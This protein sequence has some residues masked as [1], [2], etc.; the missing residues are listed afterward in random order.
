MR[1][2]E[3]K[4]KT[5]AVLV[6]V[7]ALE[8]LMLIFLLYIREYLLL[9]PMGI[10]FFLI[11]YYYVPHLI[12]WVIGIEYIKDSSNRLYK[13]VEEML[14]NYGFIR[15]RLGIANLGS[16]TSFS[17]KKSPHDITLVLSHKARGKDNEYLAG[18]LK[19]ETEAQSAMEYLMT[20]GWMIL[21][22]SIILVALFE[23]GLF[24]YGST[25][26]LPSVGF[27]CNNMA[28]I[29]GRLLTMNIGT[30]SSMHIYG[31]ACTIGSAAPTNFT[32]VNINAIQGK[33][34]FVGTTCPSG[35]GSVSGTLWIEYSI[36]NYP[37]LIAKLGTFVASSPQPKL[38]AAFDGK[39]SSIIVPYS[40]L[41]T[42]GDPDF[43]FVAWVNPKGYPSVKP[44][45][46]FPLA[47][48]IFER[49]PS[50]A[51]GINGTGYLSWTINYPGKAMYT[52]AYAPL[53]NFTQV[54]LAFNGSDVSVYK[55]GKLVSVM[56]GPIVN[57]SNLNTLIIG[58]RN[59]S[60]TPYTFFNGTIA[61]IQMYNT[62]L[63]A[64]Q[65]RYLYSEGLYG[66]P[67]ANAGIVAWWPLDGNAN[68]YSGN[69][70][71]GTSNSVAWIKP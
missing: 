12:S 13:T 46:G 10:V 9:I 54:V 41:F 70:N 19:K 8:I 48:I 47:D 33:I 66:G 23:L 59:A 42:V 32:G 17:F 38:A 31:I 29:G 57:N 56:P 6:S 44:G 5:R 64:Q 15:F 39:N 4:Q 3:A 68:D 18:I 67:I 52:N 51:W 37:D 53:D 30:Y 60:G 14:L 25:V 2:L 7:F 28:L 40:Q 1:N 20:Y 61:N 65:I 21:I 63:S 34:S 11:Q 16:Q 69:G 45:R 58:A 55:N 22:L 26:C 36:P 24:G 27:L 49:E 62:T 71:N 35:S 50:Y 43:T